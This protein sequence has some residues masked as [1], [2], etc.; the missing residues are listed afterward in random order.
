MFESLSDYKA[1]VLD[2]SVMFEVGGTPIFD[3]LLDVIMKSGLDVY[4]S[5]TFKMLQ[6][7]R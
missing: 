6:E 3:E 4:V 1:L 7:S 2:Y 5:K